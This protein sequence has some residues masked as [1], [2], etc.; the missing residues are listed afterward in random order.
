MAH[1]HDVAAVGGANGID[2]CAAGDA[3]EEAL[4]AAL[5]A[6]LQAAR[7]AAVP[8]CTAHTA[9]PRLSQGDDQVWGRCVAPD[10]AR[11]AHRWADIEE[12]RRAPRV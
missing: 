2:W 6:D 10:R 9:G 8:N 3:A 1:L 4:L 7:D 5:Q 11:L 12:R